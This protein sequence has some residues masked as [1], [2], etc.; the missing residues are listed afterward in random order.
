MIVSLNVSKPSE[1]SPD[2]QGE[3]GWPQKKRKIRNFCQSPPRHMGEIFLL[4]ALAACRVG[5]M[6]RLK[7]YVLAVESFRIQL[8]HPYIKYNKGFGD[9]TRVGPQGARS[10]SP[11]HAV[12]SSDGQQESLDISAT[13]VP[14]VLSVPS[15]GR[16]PPE[17]EVPVPAWCALQTDEDI[18]FWAKSAA[19]DEKEKCCL[20]DLSVP[21]AVVKSVYPVIAILV[22]GSCISTMSESVPQNCRPPFPTF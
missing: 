4:I 18:G 22:S 12:F 8:L 11:T 5:H 16:Q 15:Q 3:N 14:P 2:R 7:R 1:H 19:V 21:G 10:F 20:A 6:R 13:M 9:P 17:T